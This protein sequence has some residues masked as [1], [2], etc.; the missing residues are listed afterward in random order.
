MDKKWNI[1]LKLTVRRFS[2]W[3][4]HMFCKVLHGNNPCWYYAEQRRM[5]NKW[6]RIRKTNDGRTSRDDRDQ[7]VNSIPSDTSLR[8][9]QT[10]RCK[11]NTGRA[12]HGPS[13]RRHWSERRHNRC[14]GLQYREIPA[15]PS[16]VAFKMFFVR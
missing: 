2:R 11:G 8:R 5:I 16:G 10:P 12:F 3:I 1:M 13:R 7:N 9:L 6:T 4:G 14:Y 15:A